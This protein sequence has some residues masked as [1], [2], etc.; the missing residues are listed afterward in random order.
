M[1]MVVLILALLA[2]AVVRAQAQ[3]TIQFK[4]ILTGSSEVPPN[5]DPTI[6]TATFTLDG[7]SLSF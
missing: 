5:G 2:C 4:A 7:K 6:G 1:K 3:G